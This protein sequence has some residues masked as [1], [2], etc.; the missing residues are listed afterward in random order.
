[1]NVAV[2]NFTRLSSAPI[3]LL[4]LSFLFISSVSCSSTEK[5]TANSGPYTGEIS[6]KQ[7]IEEYPHFR[8]GYENYQPSPE[9]SAAVATLQGKSLVVLFGTWCHDSE[10]EIPRLLKLLDISGVELQ[11]LSLH[12]VDYKKHEPSNLHT[13]Y[14]MTHSPTIILLEDGVEL[15]R[16]VEKP[17][18]SL[19]EDLAEF[20]AD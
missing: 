8:S 13:L 20:V 1:M 14:N 12:G 11:K 5:G 7:L 6:A 17:E 10:R 2:A 15:G 4:I 9:E 18:K 3:R 16:I 19:G